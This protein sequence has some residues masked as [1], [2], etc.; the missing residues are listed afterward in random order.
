MDRLGADFYR[1]VDQITNVL[2]AKPL[3][4]TIPIGFEDSFVG[5]VDILSQKAYEIGFIEKI[6]GRMNKLGWVSPNDRKEIKALLAGLIHEDN[7]EEFLA[8]TCPDYKFQQC[9]YYKLFLCF[10]ETVL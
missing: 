6:T 3:V 8:I 10:F 5:V 4:M 7:A 1:V 2:A 9:V